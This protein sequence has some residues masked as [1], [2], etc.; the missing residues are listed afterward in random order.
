MPPGGPFAADLGRGPWRRP[1]RCDGRM[2]GDQ[3]QGGWW[4]R[5]S[6]PDRGVSRDLGY[7]PSP[8]HHHWRSRVDTGTGHDV[9]RFEI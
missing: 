6:L 3:L 9:G 8:H 2:A 1:R 7:P 4:H 5:R